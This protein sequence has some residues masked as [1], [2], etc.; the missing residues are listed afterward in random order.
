MNLQIW[1]TSSYMFGEGV[2]RASGGGGLES[3]SKLH[4]DILY[5]AADF[6]KETYQG[7]RHHGGKGIKACVSLQ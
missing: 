7:R 6:R 1:E 2:Y 4:N 5:R 3:H